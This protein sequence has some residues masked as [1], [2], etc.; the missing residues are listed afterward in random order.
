M[1]VLYRLGI[2]S[3]GRLCLFC[4]SRKGA[5]LFIKALQGSVGLQVPKLEGMLYWTYDFALLLIMIG[6]TSTANDNLSTL[7]CSM[8][9]LDP[10]L[11]LAHQ[12]HDRCQC[13]SN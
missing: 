7:D 3:V 10:S 1:E 13:R 5:L 11:C 4:T 12:Y 8:F 2:I 6:R 9:M